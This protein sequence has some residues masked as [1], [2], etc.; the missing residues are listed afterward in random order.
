[1]GSAALKL[2]P[3]FV[4]ILSF[5]ACSQEGA[6]AQSTNAPV[7]VEAPN[8]V[9][10]TANWTVDAANS[11]LSF[12][13]DQGGDAFTGTF[14][15][16]TPLIK[17]DPNDLASA[18]VQVSVDLTSADAGD[19]ERTGALPGKDWFAVKSFQTAVFL[20]DQFSALGG[21]RFE[22]IGELRIKDIAQPLTL[23]FSLDID[24]D[25]ATMNGK[26]SINRLDFNIGSG[27]WESEEWVAHK[28][29]IAVVITATRK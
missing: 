6:E 28:I 21:N 19:A 26:V 8:A 10:F 11:T 18:Q 20:A 29:D 12:S 7:T 15:R 4:G 17:F 3:L 22:A 27:S 2:L 25:T 9:A 23:P 13:G 1:M 16:F 24:G 5:S 14:S